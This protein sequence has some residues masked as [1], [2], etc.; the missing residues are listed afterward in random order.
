MRCTSA[1]INGS[2]ANAPPPEGLFGFGGNDRL[3]QTGYTAHID[4]MLVTHLL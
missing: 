3:I 1:D 4:D 2:E